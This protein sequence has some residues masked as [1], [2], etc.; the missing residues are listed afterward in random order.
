MRARKLTAEFLGT[1]FLV[2]GVIGSGIAAE[3]LS[4]ADVGLQLLENSLAT[5]GILVAI[6]LAFG[7][8][9]GAHFNP[10]VT[11]AELTRGGVT[12]AEA[13]SYIL[14][15][16]A[17]GIVGAMA[18]NVMFDL[19]LVNISSKDRSGWNLL[20]AEGVATIGLLLVIYGV[21]HAGKP[22]LAAASVAGYI[23]GAYFFT[24]STS[25][26][27]P[28]VTISRTLSNSFAGI[29][30]ANAI[31]FVIAQVIA[32]GAGIALINWL[33]PVETQVPAD[34]VS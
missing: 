29:D 23:G 25:F 1:A 18:A 20:F 24:A 19:D 5:A 10:V 17:G 4:P 7:P 31:G 8:V 11:L 9:S 2:A 34:G 15:Q 12:A 32:G 14:A 13:G 30:P 33:W 22:S 27:N 28:A 16:L 26:A 6:I 21:V 3:R